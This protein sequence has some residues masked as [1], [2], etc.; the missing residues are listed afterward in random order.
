M[1]Y[2][3]RSESG[4]PAAW[5]SDGIYKLYEFLMLVGQRG[6]KTLL[7]ERLVFDGKSWYWETQCSKEGSG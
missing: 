4:C 3:W 2:L 7:A 6:L 1:E 5:P